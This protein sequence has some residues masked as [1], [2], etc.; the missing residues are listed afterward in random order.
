MDILI[1]EVL[2]EQILIYGGVAL[3][4]ILIVVKWMTCPYCIAAHI[5][6]FA[7]WITVEMSR[8]RP[9]RLRPALLAAGAAFVVVTAV[10]GIGDASHRAALAREAER[11]RTAAQD[12]KVALDDAVSVGCPGMR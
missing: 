3:F 11:N 9:S 5:G 4:C 6:N 12:G 8:A 1:M 7:F 10:L 2:I